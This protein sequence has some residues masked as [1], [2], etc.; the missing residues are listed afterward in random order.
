[1]GGK[2]ILI[3]GT[4]PELGFV[5]VIVKAFKQAGGIGAGNIGNAKSGD[6]EFIDAGGLL[7]C[8][9]GKGNRRNSADL[10]AGIGRK[11]VEEELLDRSLPVATPGVDIKDVF[12][13]ACASN[14]GGCNH[15]SPEEAS[16]QNGAAR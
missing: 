1:M 4:L 8:K 7:C 5:H 6:V 16:A 12:V 14:E 3:D 11:G 15:R 9:L 10:D 2:A 13:G